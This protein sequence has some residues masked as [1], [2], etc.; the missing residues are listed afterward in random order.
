MIIKKGNI[1]FENYFSLEYNHAIKSS[2]FYIYFRV[3]INSKNM[4]AL[5]MS[6]YLAL[7]WPSIW[8]PVQLLGSEWPTDI[9]VTRLHIIYHK[10]FHIIYFVLPFI[11]ASLLPHILQ[12]ISHTSKREEKYDEKTLKNLLITI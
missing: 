6:S 2:Y 12:Q 4:S 3:E 10:T 1:N 7:V 11:W 5:S 9:K 8:K